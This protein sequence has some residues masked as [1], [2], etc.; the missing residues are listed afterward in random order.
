MFT[1]IFKGFH[2][3]V[4]AQADTPV[5]HLCCIRARCI[6]YS[7]LYQVYCQ[8][9]ERKWLYTRTTGRMYFLRPV[10]SLIKSPCRFRSAD[11]H[12]CFTRTG[13]AIYHTL[14]G[15][16]DNSVEVALKW[17]SYR[18]MRKSFD[19]IMKHEWKLASPT[20][21]VWTVRFVEWITSS[22]YVS[23]YYIFLKYF[24]NRTYVRW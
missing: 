18:I 8:A 23:N 14:Y 1:N 12:I 17:R 20:L 15:R 9:S 19:S 13:H 5:R 22:R 6:I 4:R 16:S 24:L 3:W 21:Y 11:R 2:F 10:I 7:A